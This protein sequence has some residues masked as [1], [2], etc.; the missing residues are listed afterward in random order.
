MALSLLKPRIQSSKYLA[1]W[2]QLPWGVKNLAEYISQDVSNN[3]KQ[4]F[5]FIWSNIHSFIIWADFYKLDF[6]N[7]HA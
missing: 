7:L 5:I 4:L 6:K 3:F 1:V 2:D